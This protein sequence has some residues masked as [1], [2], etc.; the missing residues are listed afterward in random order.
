M[1]SPQLLAIFVV[2]SMRRMIPGNAGIEK[3]IV[4]PNATRSPY[5][6]CC[7]DGFQHLYISYF[8]SKPASKVLPRVRMIVSLP[9]L[10]SVLLG[11][12]PAREKASI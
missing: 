12:R 9:Q 10:F 11:K 1:N 8:D 6:R 4:S 7:G 2:S 5:S 3:R